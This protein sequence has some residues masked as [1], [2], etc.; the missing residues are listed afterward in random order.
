MVLEDAIRSQKDYPIEYRLGLEEK[1][2]VMPQICKTETS[3]AY[4]PQVSKQEKAAFD[5]EKH[6]AALS[7]SLFTQDDSKFKHTLNSVASGDLSLDQ[8]ISKL[9]DLIS[10]TQNYKVQEEARQ[11]EAK[12]QLFCNQFEVHIKHV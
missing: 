11:L 8:M 1:Y 5:A 3:T 9:Q 4:L 10:Q 2:P 12:G 7:S 6:A